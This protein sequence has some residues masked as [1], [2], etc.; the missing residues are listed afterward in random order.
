LLREPAAAPGQALS[1]L[2]R[3]T[4]CRLIVS[5]ALARYA[6]VPF[7][8]AL[9]GREANETLAA[10]VFRGTHGERVEGWRIRVTPA[11]RGHRR[12]ACALDAA[13][14]EAIA[15]AAQEHGLHVSAIEPAWAAGFNAARRRLPASCWFAVS[16]PGRLVLGLL[17]DG[18]WRHIAAERCG[19]DVP[20]ALRQAVARAAILADD[21]AA[22]VLPRWV[23]HFA[24]A[25]P[26]V[27]AVA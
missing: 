6:L 10:H 8:A 13:L 26:V 3:G 27:E 11:P 9:V 19:A 14:L 20:A 18:E 2:A 25:T 4:R 24:H 21:A 1:A 5:N 22:K 16:E 23:A 12:I 7:S 17:I 15:A